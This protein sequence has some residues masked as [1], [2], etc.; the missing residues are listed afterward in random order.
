M[1][2]LKILTLNEETSTLMFRHKFSFADEKT[3]ADKVE[4]TEQLMNVLLLPD[5]CSSTDPCAFMHFHQG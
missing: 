5:S 2:G 3:Q 1:Q 4:S